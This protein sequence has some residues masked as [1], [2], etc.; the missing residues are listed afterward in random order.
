MKYLYVVTEEDY[1]RAFVTYSESLFGRTTLRR[2]DKPMTKSTRQRI[3]DLSYKPNYDCNIVS[4]TQRPA[5][6]ITKRGER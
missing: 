5:L 3:A 4:L 6:V 1:V 2:Y